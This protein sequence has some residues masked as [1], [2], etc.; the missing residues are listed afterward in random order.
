MPEQ[1]ADLLK[2]L[3]SQVMQHR[4][5]NSILG[6]TLCVL[7][8]TE[9]FEP[10]RNLLHRGFLRILGHASFSPATP[11]SRIHAARSTRVSISLRS[12]TKSIGLVRNASAPF[13]SALRFIS[14]S[15]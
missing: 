15:P 11:P 14:A 5:V 4:G 10:V 1:D 2:V 12:V 3:V 9:F 8:Q 13:C 6:K 7:L